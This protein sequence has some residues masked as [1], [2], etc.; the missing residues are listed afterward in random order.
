[1]LEMDGKSDEER[2]EKK[3]NMTSVQALERVETGC[4]DQP[5]NRTPPHPSFSAQLGVDTECRAIIH[6]DSQPTL[7]HFNQLT[8]QSASQSTNQQT[9]QQVSQPISQ[10]VSQ[11]PT[12]SVS[13]PSIPQSFSHSTD[14]DPVTWLVGQPGRQVKLLNSCE[15]KKK[16]VNEEEK[17][18]QGRLNGK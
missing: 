7:Q 3:G 15:R 2:G 18:K 12:N 4:T 13:P 8:N 11:L 1:M 16:C 9:G 5:R 6:S 14:T 17:E 10:P